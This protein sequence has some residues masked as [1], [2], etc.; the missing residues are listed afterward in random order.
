LP[1]HY[2]NFRAINAVLKNIYNFELLPSQPT[3]QPK[4]SLLISFFFEH[5]FSE[6]WKNELSISDIPESLPQDAKKALAFFLHHL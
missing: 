4:P 3:L 5:I 2:S 1:I 6:T